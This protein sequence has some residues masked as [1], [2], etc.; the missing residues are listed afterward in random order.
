MVFILRDARLVDADGDTPEGDLT[1]AEG[2]IAVAGASGAGHDSLDGQENA[3]ADTTVDAAGM[4]IMPGFIDVHT[5]GGGGFNLHTT[6]PDE[7]R[8][9]AS[10]APSGGTT[11]FLIGVVGAP[12]SLPE[13]QL[14]ASVATL[15][16]PPANAAEPLG[17]H[18]EGPYISERRRGAHLPSWIRTPNDAETTQLLELARGWLRIVTLAPELPGAETLMRRLI[19]AGVTVS[20]G[21]SDATYEQALD[22]IRQGVTHMTHCCNAMR[23]LL[24]RDPGPLSALSE[25]ATV[26][27]EIIADG[28]HVHP[29]MTRA[30]LKLMGA[31]RAILI[32]DA[33]AGAG[34]KSDTFEFGGQ[35][36]H[37]RHGAAWLADGTLTGSVLTMDQALRNISNMTS[38]TL[39]QASAMLARNPARAAKVSERK[40]LLRHGYD[41]DLVILD[42]DL[43]IHATYCGGA[44]AYATDTWRARLDGQSARGTNGRRKNGGRKFP[45]RRPD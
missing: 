24:H 21:H 2:R 41:A 36:A 6:Q 27:G 22:S 44:L 33:Q 31:E 38:V 17:I 13:A 37:I 11:A 29:A 1:V 26:Y 32:T 20:L 10:W 18:L 39:S 42:R 23:P 30:L 43:T 9:Y 8:A 5:H 15:R 12:N 40:G 45:E 7:I 4:I 25:S 28:V 19:E 3:P 14:S 35:A 34:G 16:E